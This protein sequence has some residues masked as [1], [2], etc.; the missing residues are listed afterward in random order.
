MGTITIANNDANENPFTFDVTCVVDPAP[1]PEIQVEEASVLVDGVSTVDFGT[2]TQGTSVNRVIT[3][4]NLGDAE[5][6]LTGAAA[7]IPAGYANTTYVTNSLSNTNDSTT[8]G[9]TCDASSPGTFT[10][11]VS[12]INNDADENPFTFDVTCVVDPAPA[13]EIQVQ[14]G[15]ATILTSGVSTVDL[16]AT[17][18]GT[19]VNE[20]FTITNLGNAELTLMGAAPTIPADY[21]TTNY[22]AA[23]LPNTNDATTFTLTCD[24]TAIGTFMGTVSIASNDADE[25]PFT[26][27]VTCQVDPPPAPEIQVEDGAPTILSSGVSTVDLGVTT[28]GTPIDM[29][30]TI[31]NLGSAELTLTGAAPTIPADYSTSNYGATSLPNTNDATTFTLTCDATAIGTFTGTVSLVGF[32]YLRSS[33]AAE[34]F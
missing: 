32:G 27:D 34:D 1:A 30:F 31:T 19:S 20:V 14:D 11:T 13:L 6:T 12:I 18:Q 28:Q 5:L 33:V 25:N 16:G 23:S 24:A 15:S 26:V 17:T 29:I 21:S 9:L 4:T 22:G 3:I 8:F 10:G 2:T 7:T